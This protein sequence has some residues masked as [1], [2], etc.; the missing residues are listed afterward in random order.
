MTMRVLHL[1]TE[2]TW[3]GG[4]RQTLLTALEQRRQGLDAHIACR[5]GSPLETAACKENIPTISLPIFAPALLG[6]LAIAFGK[7]DLLHCHTGRIHS[8]VAVANLFCGKPV[9][10]SRR[11][12][13]KPKKTA[14]N[15]FKYQRAAKVICVSRFVADQMINWGVP[16][17][18]VAVVY[19]AVT[20][21]NFLPREKCLEQLRQKNGDVSGKRLVGNIAALVPHKDQ[22][23]LLRAAR[24]VA[25]K[26]ADVAFVVIGEGELRADLLRLRDEL[27]LT[28]VVHFTGF[29]PQAQESLPAFDVFVMSSCMEGL[30]SIV[31][32]AG[33]AGVPV[34][35]TA[36]GGLPEIVVHE[37]TGLL[38]PVGDAE[39]LAAAILRLLDDS[40][41]AKK[42]VAA[43]QNKIRTEFS[44]ARMAQ[45][46]TDIYC[47]IIGK[48]I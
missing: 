41:L 8:L 2:K 18:R 11:V 14:F 10:V 15:R 46:Y 35:A 27:N 40:V 38:T 48:P 31:L 21:V 16:A 9:V 1:N 17:E 6:K 19:D 24:L 12:D 45:S 30:G 5:R 3:R 34:A 43:A 39:K 13:F 32:D 7:F 29:I 4:E 25:D 26:R 44:L 37:Q 47:E 23:T 20:V 42:L 36:G 33:L 22:A 28:G